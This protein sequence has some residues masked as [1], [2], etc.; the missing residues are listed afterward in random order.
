MYQWLVLLPP[1]VV[2][3]LATVTRK[4]LW[5][6]IAGIIVGLLILRDF[7]LPVVAEECVM[8]VWKTSQ[9]ANLGSWDAFLQSGNLFICLFLLA[10]AT[11]VTMLRYSGGAHAYGN[12]VMRFLKRPQQAEMASLFLSLFFC[13]DDYFSSLTVGAVM[14]PVADRF[15]VARVKLAL[16]VN[17]M[18]APLAVIFPITGW[19]AEIM[20]Q[21]GQSGVCPSVGPECLV[22][23]EVFPFYLSTIPFIFYSFLVV[24]ALWF[25]A[26]T[27]KNYGLLRKHEE[28]AKRT[29]NLFAGKMP[30]NR[31]FMEA[32]HKAVVHASLLDFFVP[33]GFLFATILVGILYFG[34][35]TGFGGMHPFVLALQKSNVPAALFFGALIT[36]LVSFLFLTVRGHLVVKLLPRIVHEGVSLMIPSVC[37]LILI[38]TFS[39]LL[40]GDL[41]AGKYLAS[42]LV[43]HVS[44]AFLPALFFVVTAL[45]AT[46][47]GSAW[48]AIGIYIPLAIPMLVELSGIVTPV[49]PGML[50]LIFPLVGAIISG[51]IVGN[52]LAPISDTMLMASASTGAYHS[53]VVRVQA[54]VCLPVIGVVTVSFICAGV[55]ICRGV[56]AG[57]AALLSLGVGVVLIAAVLTGLS[58]IGKKGKI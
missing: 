22:Q 24:A 29:G 52:H 15:K 4:I 8:R 17:G 12:F 25:L 55:A 3:G 47:I 57:Y 40:R 23:A 33:I 11:I 21:L 36:M 5:A 9:L 39:A 2:I 13:V 27:G 26:I 35:W 6:I 37:M 54:S 43:G 46:M 49:Q 58:L 45:S 31:R 51:G 48:G 14:Q 38:W 10:V 1:L 32:D 16:L 7:S 42:L 53:D 50:P 44:V 19:V 56:G 30:V 34:D 28:I 41:A 20:V 18:A